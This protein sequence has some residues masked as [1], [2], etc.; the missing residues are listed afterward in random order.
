M[1]LRIPCA[2]LALLGTTLTLSS[3]DYRNSPGNNNNM[4]V[5]FNNP[6]GYRNSDVNL[7]SVNYKQRV[8]APSGEGSAVAIKNGTVKE[9]IDSAPAGKSATS[10]QS[11]SGQLGTVND[12]Q[13]IKGNG[14][15][16]AEKK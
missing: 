13:P 8:E 4:R 1:T 11:A 9:Q 15:Q 10:P 6:P 7:D 12:V 2:A 3:C 14:D 5:G 16:P